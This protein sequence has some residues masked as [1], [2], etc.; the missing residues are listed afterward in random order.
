MSARLLMEVALRVLG[1]WFL[2]SSIVTMTPM[3]SYYLAN[4]SLGG[5][6]VLISYGV[7]FVVQLAL[8]VMLIRWAP[9]MAAR[10][11]PLDADEP[12]PQIRVGPG[13][14]YHTACFVLGVYLLVLGVESSGRWAVGALPTSF[15]MQGSQLANI[16]VSAIV[17][18]ASGLLLIFGSRRIGQWMSNLR[19]D[20]DSIPQQQFSLKLLLII[21]GV[22][23]VILGAIRMITVGGL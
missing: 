7:A 16:A 12:E 23:A 4:V 9:S 22:V 11:Y 10:F 15:G 6:G 19:Y 1:I 20:P 2:L 21:T 8:G 13:D 17:Y 5:L 18:T 3:A 14:I